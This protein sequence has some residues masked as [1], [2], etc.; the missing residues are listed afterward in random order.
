MKF[1]TVNAEDYSLFSYLLVFSRL[2]EKIFC[3]WLFSFQKNFER[4]GITKKR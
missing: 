3:L 4:N 2:S 1:G